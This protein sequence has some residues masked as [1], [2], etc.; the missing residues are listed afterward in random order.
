MRHN[1]VISIEQL[2]ELRNIAETARN[3][4]SGCVSDHDVEWHYADALDRIIEEIKELIDTL[5]RSS[6]G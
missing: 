5:P 2:N 3:D 6:N 1:V 4:L